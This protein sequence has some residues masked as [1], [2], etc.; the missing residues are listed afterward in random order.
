M[1][2]VLIT[3]KR[4]NTKKILLGF[5]IVAIIV[6]IPFYS[7]SFNHCVDF[8]NGLVGS[9]FST[10]YLEETY[11]S[12]FIYAFLNAMYYM[13]AIVGAIATV[14]IIIVGII[15]YLCLSKIELTVTDKRVYGKAIFG[16]HVDL[17]LDKIS[18]VGLAWPKAISV[19]T[20]SGRVTFFEIINRDE[21][22]ECINNLLIE[23]QGKA[24]NEETKQEI[25]HVSGAD[26]LKKYKDLL[27][28]G[29]ITQEE[30]EAKKKQI[31]GI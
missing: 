13:S 5:F 11:G 28:E 8:Y 31:L 3:S 1:E 29:I 17:P 24:K 14:V 26:E 2:K 23:R 4:Y 12:P 21:I 7:I 9:E 22:Y 15:V 18:A 30:F 10:G 16:R 6:F 27:N 20:S 25:H 19:A